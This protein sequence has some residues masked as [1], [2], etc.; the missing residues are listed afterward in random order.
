M[1]VPLRPAAWVAG[2]ILT[3]MVGAAAPASAETVVRDDPTGDAPERIDVTRARYTHTDDQI[4]VVARVPEL[5]DAGT[6]ALSISRFGIFEAGYVVQIR[7][8]PDEQPR[9]RLLFFNHF[10]FEPR[11]CADVS[12][13]WGQRRVTLVV[14]RSCL[15]GHARRHVFAQFGI[16]HGQQVDRASAVRRLARS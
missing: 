13:T 1:K 5:G 7:K 2:S 9:A 8:R 15:T 10:D 14:D 12:G 6:A 16:Q 4:R 3:L 11:R